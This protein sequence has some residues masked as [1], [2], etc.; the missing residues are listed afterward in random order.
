MA[1]PSNP[2]PVPVHD[3]EGIL[4]LVPHLLGFRPSGSLV[5]VLTSGGSLHATL[6]IDLPGGGAARRP[7]RP[8]RPA[9][10]PPGPSPEALARRVAGFLGTVKDATGVFLVVYAEPP[11]RPAGPEHA[12]LG[13]ARPGPAARPWSALVAA[14]GRELEAIGLEVQDAWHV[15]GGR[16]R[17][18]LC[19]DP[20]CCPPEG[21]PLEGI[22]LSETN[23]Q[24]VLA[25][26]SPRGA[27]PGVPEL[28]AA[29]APWADPA[30]VRAAVRAV[31]DGADPPRRT[32][33]LMGWCR[34]LDADGRDALAVP[35]LL[36]RLRA[37]PE[38]TGA[39]LA[40]LHD[41]AIRDCL[42]SA[43]GLS[44]ADGVAALSAIERGAERARCV[45]RMADFMLGVSP[46]T[47][48][49]DRLDRLRELCGGL[50]P[51]A[52]EQDRCALLCLAAWVEWARGRGTA[53]GALLDAC[54]A[55]SPDYR[56]G[57]LLHRLIG[58]GRMPDWVPDPGRAWRGH[59]APMVLPPE[60][61]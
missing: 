5:C 26:S 36:R 53:A 39:L 4:A 43:A 11:V 47:P 27:E 57:I 20:S 23:L 9:Q 3:A 60:E 1:I 40:A 18:Y 15:G 32:A 13:P 33:L 12:G 45:R 30:A 52:R 19:T 24:L 38:E 55:E 25:G 58:S 59:R 17:S 42:P 46:E 29:A 16:W 34:L 14:L 22:E 61:T 35:D 50:V 49:W 10:H 21:K 54:V 6:R 7:G 51:A 37:N 44:A 2:L 41:K 28:D 48:D 31:L 56:L 8:P